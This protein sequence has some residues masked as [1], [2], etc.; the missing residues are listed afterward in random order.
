M[1]V[2]ATVPV[3]LRDEQLLAKGQSLALKIAERDGVV[4]EKRQKNRELQA[5]I[6]R[7]DGEISKLAE[8]V[9]TG[10][11]D[12]RQGE[13]FV[14]DLSPEQAAAALGQVAARVC[15]DIRATSCP[16]H[17]E[18]TCAAE[19]VHAIDCPLHGVNSEHAKA[20]AAAP[21]AEE[22]PEVAHAFSAGDGSDA[23]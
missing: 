20:R 10:Y 22:E 21:A 17:G 18:C 9:R 6:D 16:I 4:E 5:E 1:D 23:A 12:R 19:N 7:I 13:L 8:E 14:G 3:K 15:T 11:E 2:E